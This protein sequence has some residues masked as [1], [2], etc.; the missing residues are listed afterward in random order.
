MKLLLEKSGKVLILWILSTAS[1]SSEK[2]LVR[3]RLIIN[4]NSWT[5][6]NFQ[7]Q[8]EIHL[9]NIFHFSTFLFSHYLWKKSTKSHT[10]SINPWCLDTIL[11][12][13]VFCSAIRDCEFCF[14]I[15]I[16][17]CLS[18]RTWAICSLDNWMAFDSSLARNVRA[19]IRRANWWFG[20]ITRSDILNGTYKNKL[21]YFCWHKA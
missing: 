18:A 19:T 3:H 16:A 15:R 17:L 9:K 14:S 6:L 21:F 13:W 5:V 7:K 4:T 11:S 8:I 2:G 1:K 12:K 20:K 10:C